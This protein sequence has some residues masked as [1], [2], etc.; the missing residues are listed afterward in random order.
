MYKVLLVDD[1]ADVREGLLGEIDWDQHGFT[2]VGTAENGQEALELCERLAPDVVIT[3]ISMPFMNGLELSHWLRQHQPLVKIVILTGYDE[4]DYARQAVRLSVDEYLLKPFS[5]DT[6]SEL[7]DKIKHRIE[8]EVAEREDI[9]R[10]EEHYRTSLPLL[11]EGFLASLLTR[12]LSRSVIEEKAHSYGLRLKGSGYAAAVL[13]LHHGEDGERA[14]DSDSLRGSGD[15]ELMLQAMLNIVREWWDAGQLGNVFIHQESV[16]LI[17]IDSECEGEA[18]ERRMSETLDNIVRSIRHYLKLSTTIG[19][20]SVTTDLSHL[21]DSYSDALLALDYRLV[22]GSGKVIYIGDMEHRIGKKLRLDELKASALIRGLKVGTPAELREAV[23]VIFAEPAQYAYA[24]GDIQV[25]LLEVC[26]TVWRT[27][28]DAGLAL[29]DL[30]GQSFQLHME[31][32]R[33]AGMQEMEL[34]F[35]DICLRILQAIASKRQYTYKDLVEKAILYTKEHYGDPDLSIQQVCA[36]LHISAGYFS[37]VFKKET[38]MTF[39]Q[40]LMHIR[41]EAAMAL[42]RETELKA[43]EIAER[44]GFADPNYFSFCFKKRLGIS[45]KEYR[46]RPEANHGELS[47]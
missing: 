15:M 13:A 36:M 43:F 25:Y 22:L 12:K 4:F 33:Y 46:S 16:A 27:A 18:W 20:G 28:Q 9:H 8:A 1:E 21:K 5:S 41:M 17:G 40:Y 37:G 44:V 31:L 10:L 32:F 30:F 6:F 2:I 14:T 29:D 7:L 11:G 42:L 45:P 19:V 47:S 24:Y 38:R 34:W 23:S 26:T 35:H 3:D 39:G